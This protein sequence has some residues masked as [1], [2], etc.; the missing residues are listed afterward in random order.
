M[1]RLY[2]Q[3]CQHFNEH[4]TFV[5]ILALQDTDHW[6]VHIRYVRMLIVFVN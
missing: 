1:I 5:H 2:Q 4:F 6:M 3:Q